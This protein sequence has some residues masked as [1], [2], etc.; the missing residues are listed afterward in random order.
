[1]SK[2]GPVEPL[3]VLLEALLQIGE[4][5]VK[6]ALDGIDFGVFCAAG[7]L[8]LAEAFDGA[9]DLHETT[10]FVEGDAAVGAL[11]GGFGLFSGGIHDGGY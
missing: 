7:R 10:H 9:I 8:A 5:S 3:L 4:P 11:G 6:L 1:M 2:L